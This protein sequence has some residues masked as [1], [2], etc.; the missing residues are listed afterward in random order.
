MKDIKTLTCIV[1]SSAIFGSCIHI[2]EPPK[3]DS[4]R[5]RISASTYDPIYAGNGVSF[6]G[7]G[8][9]DFDGDIVSY[10]WDFGDGDR[11]SGARVKHI[12]DAVGYFS[13]CLTI[14][15]NEGATSKTCVGVNVMTR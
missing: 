10:R 8:S 1:L 3:N 13:T 14:E 9:Y 4:P 15:D 12:Y 5:V 7:S 11:A 6:D 2:N